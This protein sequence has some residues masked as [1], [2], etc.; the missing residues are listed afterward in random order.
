MNPVNGYI[1]LRSN[2]AY[3]YYDGFLLGSTYNL[4][5]ENKK[6][7]RCE[8]KDGYFEAVFEVSAEKMIE[9]DYIKTQFC[10]RKNEIYGC[11]MTLIT[12]G[13]D[14]Y[15]ENYLQNMNIP[16]VK[17][18]KDEIDGLVSGVNKVSDRPAVEPKK[19]ANMLS[20]MVRNIANSIFS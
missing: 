3:D 17:L 6:F 8:K 13:S 15:I 19:K 4:K 2:G 10:E 1:Y 12:K 16:Y 18:T 7:V 9:Y 14:K 20:K 11:E 5:K